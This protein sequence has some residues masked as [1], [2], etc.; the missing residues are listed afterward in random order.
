VTTS[1]WGCIGSLSFLARHAP[2]SVSGLVACAR[3]PDGSVFWT[4]PVASARP[5]CGSRG[6]AST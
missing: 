3:W 5:L 4:R 1:A 6:R 2:N